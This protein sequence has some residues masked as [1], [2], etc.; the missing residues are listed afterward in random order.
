M[1]PRLA[2]WTRAWWW[3]A[4]AIRP[5]CGTNC[6]R[7][8]VRHGLHRYY[9]QRPGRWDPS[10]SQ[11]QGRPTWD[12]WSASIAAVISLRACAPLAASS[13]SLAKLW[14]YIA[15]SRGWVKVSQPETSSRFTC[16]SS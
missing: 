8:R 4:Q 12:H 7:L 2:S 16:L 10:S 6:G 11:D 9:G 1:S 14:A 3:T 15:I 13:D 5:E